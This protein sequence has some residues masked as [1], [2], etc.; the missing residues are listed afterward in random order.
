MDD[1]GAV[2]TNLYVVPELEIENPSAGSQSDELVHW[3]LHPT[4]RHEITRSGTERHVMHRDQL[5]SLVMMTDENADWG[6]ERVYA[7]FGVDIGP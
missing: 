7:P 1:G 4:I 5:N 3:H 2:T 6:I